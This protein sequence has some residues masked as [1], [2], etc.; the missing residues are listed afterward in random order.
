[1]ILDLDDDEMSFL[2][3]AL[4]DSADVFEDASDLFERLAEL[5]EAEENINRARMGAINDAL[6]AYHDRH[7]ENFGPSEHALYESLA[8]KLGAALGED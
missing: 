8:D 2:V 7:A 4:N 6:E 3:D 5:V 1:M